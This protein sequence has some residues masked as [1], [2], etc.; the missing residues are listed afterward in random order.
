MSTPAQRRAALSATTIP[1]TRKVDATEA[2]WA[3]DLDAIEAQLAPWVVTFDGWE[4]IDPSA[5]AN[6]LRLHSDLTS[7]GYARGWLA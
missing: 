2:R 7:I 1:T 6:L 4:G 5:P 3:K